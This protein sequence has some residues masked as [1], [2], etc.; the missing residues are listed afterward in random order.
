M[1]YVLFVETV[2]GVEVMFI[3]ANSAIKKRKTSVTKDRGNKKRHRYSLLIVHLLKRFSF[4]G[5][6]F[7]SLFS[8]HRNKHGIQIFKLPLHS[9]PFPSIVIKKIRR[10]TFGHIANCCLILFQ[11]LISLENSIPIPPS[12]TSLEEQQCFIQ[13][14]AVPFTCLTI[15]WV[16]C[17]CKVPMFHSS[18]QFLLKKYNIFLYSK[19]RISHV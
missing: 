9:S 13:Q 12:L 2:S 15:S 10:V 19:K 11:S 14:A 3:S 7:N 18:S 17:C 8:N 6:Q 1:N 5:R 4:V 16:P